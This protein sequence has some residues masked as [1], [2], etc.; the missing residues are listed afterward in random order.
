[1]RPRASGYRVEFELEHPR[2]G[3]DMAERLLRREA[4]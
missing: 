2:E 4:A 3:V 1:V